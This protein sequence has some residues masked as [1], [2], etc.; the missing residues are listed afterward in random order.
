MAMHVQVPSQEVVER[1]QPDFAALKEISG[2]VVVVT[3]QGNSRDIVSRTFAPSCGVN[4]DP[5]CG[6][7]HCG[8][9]CFWSERLNKTTI[10]ACQ[11]SSRGGELVITRKGDR[12]LISGQCVSI[13]KGEYLGSI[14]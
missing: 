13:T 6:S 8:L 3:A 4:E 11:A 2:R 7:A 5:V 14:Y 1:L 12:V 10:T 9:A